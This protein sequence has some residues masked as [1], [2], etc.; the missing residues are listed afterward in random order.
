MNEVCQLLPN[1]ARDM[2][3]NALFT[4]LPHLDLIG[5]AFEQGKTQTCSARRL[6]D[7]R[8]TLRSHTQAAVASDER[9]RS[10]VFRVY[11]IS[12][13]FFLN[14][15]Q[16]QETWKRDESKQLA[17]IISQQCNGACGLRFLQFPIHNFNSYMQSVFMHMHNCFS[18]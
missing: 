4:H 18:H 16:N 3:V 11:L 5:G 13:T 8:L 17:R 1:R 15:L 6:C 10:F 7:S 14:S 12:A 2:I 9:T